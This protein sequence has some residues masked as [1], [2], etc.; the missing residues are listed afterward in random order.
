MNPLG[1]CRLRDSGVLTRDLVT[2][3]PHR[4]DL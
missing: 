3:E 4:A 1:G 2:A